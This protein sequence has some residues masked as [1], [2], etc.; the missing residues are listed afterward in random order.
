MK[1]EP[2]EDF[3]SLLNY[4]STKNSGKTVETVRLMNF[5]PDIQMSGN[6]DEIRLDLDSQ[7]SPRH[8]LSNC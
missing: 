1:V 8:R 6:L 7:F 5:E 2:I 3:R 4:S